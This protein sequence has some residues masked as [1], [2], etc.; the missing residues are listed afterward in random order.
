MI[1]NREDLDQTASSDQSDLVCPVCLG[2]NY[3]N[4]SKY[5]VHFLFL[6]SNKN[7]RKANRAD[8]D[9]TASSETV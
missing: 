4:C 3:R 9:K 8:P 7:V 2:L 6:F 5:F 1:A